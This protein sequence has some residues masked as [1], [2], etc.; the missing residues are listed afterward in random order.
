MARDVAHVG[1]LKTFANWIARE[2]VGQ[3]D[4]TS[5]H[6][7]LEAFFGAVELS[8][9]SEFQEVPHNGSGQVSLVSF[10]SGLSPINVL[11]VHRGST[12]LLYMLH[13]TSNGL[14]FSSPLSKLGSI[15]T[16]KP[17]RNQKSRKKGE[18]Y[19]LL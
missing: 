18:Y 12:S 10:I 17:K 3:G 19:M 9:Q 11:V 16:G 1:D 8:V 6:D 14:L 13:R 15:P 4:L 2:Y 5:N 7:L